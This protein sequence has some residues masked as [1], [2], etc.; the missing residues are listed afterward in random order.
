[1]GN[2]DDGLFVVRVED[3]I[4][5]VTMVT[6]ETD[7]GAYFSLHRSGT[8]TFYFTLFKVSFLLKI[9]YSPPI[10]SL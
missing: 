3:I 6:D 10:N 4:E 9:R 7:R 5:L 8:K 1:M 2:S